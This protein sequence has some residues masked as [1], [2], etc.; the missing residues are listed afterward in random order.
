MANDLVCP[1]DTRIKRKLCMSERIRSFMAVY[2]ANI[3]GLVGV[4]SPRLGQ[5]TR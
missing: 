5:F 4:I 2:R 1:N 3:F